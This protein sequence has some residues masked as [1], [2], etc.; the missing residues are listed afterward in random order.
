[1]RAKAKVS[2]YWVTPDGEDRAGK[3]GADLLRAAGYEVKVIAAGAEPAQADA[4]WVIRADLGMSEGDLRRALGG[5]NRP[6]VVVVD[7]AEHAM[8]VLPMLDDSDPSEVL[9]DVVSVSDA[10]SQ[11]VWRI[12]R[13][14]RIRRRE[15]EQLAQV[16]RDRLTSLFNRS[17]WF[18]R[19]ETMI[20]GEGA[21]GLLLLDLDHFKR[22]NDS[23]GHDAGDEILIFVADCLREWAAPDDL[24]ARFGGEEFA[25]MMRRPDEVTVADDARRF[26][27]HFCSI[28]YPILPG[29]ASDVPGAR[30]RNLGF[31]WGAPPPASQQRDVT[32]LSISGGLALVRPNLA[33]D[34]LLASADQAMYRAK[35]EGRGRLV[36]ADELA[37]VLAREGK[38]LRIDHFE[39]VTRVVTERVTNLI[40]LM[41]RRLMSEATRDAQQ[42]GLTGLHN[43]RYLDLHLERELEASVRN[44]R[45]LSLV[46]MDLDHFHDIN[47]TYGW[48]T[49]DA[50]LRAF[51]GVLEGS[52]RTID[53]SARYGGEEFCLVLP[54]TDLDEALDVAERIRQKTEQLVVLSNDGRRVP[55][56]LSAG[57]VQR[58]DELVT[59]ALLDRVAFATRSA[60][61]SGR[62]QVVAG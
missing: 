22:I 35:G 25:V 32:P 20:R 54:D 38:D 59:R 40:T 46:F 12:R 9:Q 8:R 13:L 45:A 57:V 62:N 21:V 37:E 28:R 44:H 31:W 33:L 3:L 52:V 56:T 29:G 16:H 2:A 6:T 36:V 61:E 43:R 47:M 5:G 23:Y 15:R 50:V 7:N 10:P 30:S 34:E 27:E 17:T 4:V 55:V 42:D 24:I 19:A 53:W 14:R 48:P 51:A 60:K 11:L 58:G 39:N 1:M 18:E 41:G 49:G 26:I